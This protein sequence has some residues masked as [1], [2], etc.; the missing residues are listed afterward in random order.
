M[1]QRWTCLS[2]GGIEWILYANRAEV[3]TSGCWN[4]DNEETGLPPPLSDW[5]T[6]F[7]LCDWWCFSPL[8]LSSKNQWHSDNYNLLSIS[9]CTGTSS[10]WP[11]I[12][13]IMMNTLKCVFEVYGSVS[14]K[15]EKPISHIAPYT[16]SSGRNIHLGLAAPEFIS[17]LKFTTLG[18]EFDSVYRATE[19]ET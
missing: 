12:V 3:L 6:M 14:T 5:V 1:F 17:C 11:R 2:V 9:H 4:R 8:H 16:H 18:N 15:F 7:V 10:W 19:R 13:N